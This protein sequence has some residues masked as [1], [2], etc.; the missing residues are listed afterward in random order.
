MDTYTTCSL[1]YVRRNLS[2]SGT[3]D[4]LDIIIVHQLCAG[5][6]NILIVR[7]DIESWH[8]GITGTIEI[9][10]S[11]FKSFLILQATKNINSIKSP[12]LLKSQ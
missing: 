7:K 9:R 3:S 1:V 2:I 4:R 11:D 6:L 5:I 12:H 10:I 8:I